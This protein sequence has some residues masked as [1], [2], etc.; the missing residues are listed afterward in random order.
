MA[1]YNEIALTWNWWILHYF[2]KP[3]HDWA[4]THRGQDRMAIISQMH[5]LEW[6]LLYIDSILTKICSQGSI[7]QYTIIKSPQ[8]GVTLF[9]AHLRRIRPRRRPRRRRRCRNNFCLS[10]QNLLSLTLDIWHKKYMGLGECTGWPFHDLDSR[11]RLWHRL[12]KIFLSA[13]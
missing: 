4:L 11:S 2:T 13:Q 5:F 1:A 9:S 3:P 8:S 6:K 12:A 10:R 7:W